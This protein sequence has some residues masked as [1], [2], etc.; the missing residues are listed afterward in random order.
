MNT[1]NEEYSTLQCGQCKWFNCNADRDGFESTCKRLDHKRLRFAKKVFASYDC[2]QFEKNICSDFYPAERCVW[3]LN[4]WE[5]VK[6]QIVP[7]NPNEV[8]FLNVDKDADVRYAVNALDFYNGT[9]IN[10]DGSLKWIYKKYCV[11]CRDNVTGYKI[12][13]E[14]PN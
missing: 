10:D 6:S 13:R 3:L 1:T 14:Y 8:I 2:G 7:Y 5:E 4:H 11:K 9:F 12:V